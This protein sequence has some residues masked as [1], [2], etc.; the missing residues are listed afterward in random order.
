MTILPKAVYRFSA[1]LSKFPMI[2]FIELEQKK[3]CFN[4]YG[5]TK[6]PEYPK[7]SGERRIDLEESGFL[8]SVHTTKLQ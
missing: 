2:F 3:F 4:L 8:T 5:N 6:V 7:Q 1:I